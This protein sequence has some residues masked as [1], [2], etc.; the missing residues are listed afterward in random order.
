MEEV[1][2]KEKHQMLEVCGCLKGHL[3]VLR[4][5]IETQAH[6][7]QREPLLKNNFFTIMTI[8]AITSIIATPMNV[9]FAFKQMQKYIIINEITG[10]NKN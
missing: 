9:R 8:I 6:D 2:V 7:R 10:I 1:H 3:W 5:V 4:K